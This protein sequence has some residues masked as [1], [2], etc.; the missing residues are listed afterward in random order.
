[1]G[2]WV[3]EVFM[4]LKSA[5]LRLGNSRGLNAQEVGGWEGV[6]VPEGED[7]G[8]SV[9]VM[10]ISISPEGTTLLEGCQ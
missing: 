8:V 3:G 10:K 2:H 5:L 1:M 4:I 6:L 7:V 9:I